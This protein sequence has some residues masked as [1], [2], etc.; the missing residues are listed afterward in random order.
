V[1]EMGSSM[2]F[3]VARIEL[4]FGGVNKN[5]ILLELIKNAQDVLLET[6]SAADVNEL[7]VAINT[8][9]EDLQTVIDPVEE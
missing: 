3:G 2:L 8:A 7:N 4:L 1:A 9:I 5:L 6:D